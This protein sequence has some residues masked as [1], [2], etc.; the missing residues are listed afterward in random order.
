MY[1]LS[2]AIITNGKI[3]P[4]STC[5]LLINLQRRYSNKPSLSGQ[6]KRF[7]TK[8]KGIGIIANV[9]DDEIFV[10]EADGKNPVN[11]T[12]HPEWDFMPAWSSDGQSIVFVSR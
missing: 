5:C 1:L 9:E 4:D 2:N 12:N 11:L 6:Q 7:L 10:M 8:H 3:K